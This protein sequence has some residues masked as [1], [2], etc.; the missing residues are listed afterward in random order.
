MPEINFSRSLQAFKV[1]LLPC[2]IRD[3]LFRFFFEGINHMI[4]FKGWRKQQIQQLGH[5]LPKKENF[6][7]QIVFEQRLEKSKRF[8]SMLASIFGACLLTMPFDVVMTKVITQQE[9]NGYHYKS[10]MDCLRKVINQEGVMK[11]WTGGIAGRFG[12]MLINGTAIMTMANGMRSIILE[13]YEP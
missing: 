3:S 6:N 4:I 10:M 1:A 8:N 5:E 7:S 13:A 12:Y 11:L 2:F 9:S